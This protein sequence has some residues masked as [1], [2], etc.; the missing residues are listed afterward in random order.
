MRS[1]TRW[2]QRDSCGKFGEYIHK[3]IRV[4]QPLQAI[5]GVGEKAANGSIGRGATVPGRRVKNFSARFTAPMRIRHQ[6]S[7]ATRQE[8][9]TARGRYPT[10]VPGGTAID[11]IGKKRRAVIEHDGEVMQIGGQHN[12]VARFASDEPRAPKN[13]A[14]GWR[15]DITRIE[16]ENEKANA[17]V[18]DLND[19]GVAV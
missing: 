4:A 9:T 2:V 17:P 3:V 5:W 11:H 16:I 15:C 13:G 14:W 6:C 19:F 18:Q 7:V 8:W 1:A 12:D 10:I